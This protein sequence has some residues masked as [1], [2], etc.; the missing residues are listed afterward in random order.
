MWLS[1]GISAR[2]SFQKPLEVVA[3]RENRLDQVYY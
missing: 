2:T 3:T 1:T